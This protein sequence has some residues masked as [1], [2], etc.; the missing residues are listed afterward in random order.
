MIKVHVTRRARVSQGDVYRDI[1]FIEDM[2]LKRGK[3][4]ITKTI[5]PLVIVLTQDCDLESDN[6]VRRLSPTDKKDQQLIST[7]L[8]PA[9]NSEH[10]FAGEHLSNLSRVMEK[11]SSDRRK[12]IKSNQNP[13][14]HYLEFPNSVQIVPCVI[15]FKH[16]FSVPVEKM[17]REKN[18]KWICKLSEL[19]RE[20]ISQRFASYL[21]RIG[22]PEVRRNNSKA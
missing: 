11:Q 2:E 18:S 8:V 10:F 14:Y 9:Y 13:R 3:Y 6:R 16:Y 1:D 12:L 22:L 4:F 5:Y 19:F 20:D 21:S 7:L 15:D 17:R